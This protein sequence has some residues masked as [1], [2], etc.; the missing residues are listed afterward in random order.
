MRLLTVTLVLAGLAACVQPAQTPSPPSVVE[1]LAA[2]NYTLVDLTHPYYD[3]MPTI[4]LPP[5]LGQTPPFELHLISMY[6]DKGP[7]WYWNWYQVGEHAGTHVDA[8][9]HWVSGRDFEAVDAIPLDRLICPAA[10]I[11]VK[12]KAAENADYMVTVED[13]EAWEQANG[14]LPAGAMV[15]MNSGWG[16]KFSDPKAFLGLNE[17]GEAH[18]PGFSPEVAR[19]LLENRDINGLASD[20]VSTEAMAIAGTTNPPFQVHRTMHEAGKYQIEMIANVDR[21]PAGGAY[22]MVAPM[23][24]QG[25]SGAPTRIFG[26]VP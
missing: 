6:D 5:N 26:F 24:V 20:T 25:G 21:L 13:V 23:K 2:G 11:D 7:A 14:E 12:Q 18:A 15:I 16:E 17:N 19:W 10:V 1:G 3:G 22:L 4:G 8:P 9:N